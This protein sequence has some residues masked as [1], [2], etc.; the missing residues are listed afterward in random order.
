MDLGG[1][2]VDIG[3][4]RG[5]VEG[6]RGL[7]KWGRE[8]RVIVNGGEVGGWRVEGVCNRGGGEGWFI[9]VGGGNGGKEV[10]EV[11]GVEVL[12]GDGWVRIFV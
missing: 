5:E 2:G 11:G 1:G 6:L 7:V 8:N 3:W 9:W 4:V 10:E 12:G